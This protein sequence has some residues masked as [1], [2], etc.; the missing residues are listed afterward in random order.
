M[1]LIVV[2]THWPQGDLTIISNYSFSNSYISGRYL[3]HFL[4]NCSLG[5]W[6]RTWLMRC[7]CWFNNGFGAITQQAFTWANVYPDPCCHMAALSTTIS[8]LVWV[9][10]WGLQAISNY[11]NQWWNV[12]HVINGPQWVDFNYNRYRVSAEWKCSWNENHVYLYF[13]T[14]SSINKYMFSK[15]AIWLCV[16]HSMYQFIHISTLQTLIYFE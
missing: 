2:F 7:H 13:C 6:H 3:V 11:L 10:D 1:F 16:Y 14:A 4:W 5:V 8:T 9:M 12:T 15:E